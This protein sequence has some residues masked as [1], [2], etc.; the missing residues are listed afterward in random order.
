MKCIHV[1]YWKVQT[2][3]CA[4]HPPPCDASSGEPSKCC[5]IRKLQADIIS[6]YVMNDETAHD[7]KT[8]MSYGCLQCL[9]AHR[10]ARL[11]I[12]VA[13]MLHDFS[14]SL[15]ECINMLVLSKRP[16][17]SPSSGFSS[18]PAYG[19]S[20]EQGIRSFCGNSHFCRNWF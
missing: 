9:R 7:R 14:S 19:S 6:H 17:S 10:F 2:G 11:S 12:L 8:R 13:T 20:L 3:G 16:S 4:E 15:R 1:I 5:A 18:S